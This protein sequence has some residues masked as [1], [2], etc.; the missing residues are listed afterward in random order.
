MSQ[1]PLRSAANTVLL[2]VFLTLSNTKASNA[3]DAPCVAEAISVQMNI[4]R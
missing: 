4:A 1:T 2:L 3:V